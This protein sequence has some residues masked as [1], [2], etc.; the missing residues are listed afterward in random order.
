MK[1]IA[2]VFLFFLAAGA[3][4][5]EAWW[6]HDYGYRHHRSY[7]YGYGRDYYPRYRY[8]YNSDYYRCCNEDKY[9]VGRERP[10][11]T[12]RLKKPDGT[13]IETNR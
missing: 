1:T 9:E 10:H 11:Q 7:Q 6:D 8:D 4:T 13:E 2:L 5:A 3:T 12:F